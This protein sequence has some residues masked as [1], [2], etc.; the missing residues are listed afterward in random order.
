[1]PFLFLLRFQN[2]GDDILLSRNIRW[3]WSPST[4]LEFL[5]PLAIFVSCQ[6]QEPT[7]RRGPQPSPTLGEG[8]IAT[9]A[10]SPARAR[11]SLQFAMLSSSSSS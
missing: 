2:M 8:R 11:V 9:S 3:T 10:V 7:Q 5:Q 4:Q 1:M 6:V